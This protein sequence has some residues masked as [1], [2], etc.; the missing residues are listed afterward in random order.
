[1]SLSSSS[2]FSKGRGG[3]SAPQPPQAQQQQAAAE[4]PNTPRATATHTH[5]LKNKKSSLVWK[6]FTENE[7][8]KAKC[9]SEGCSSEYTV[10]NGSTTSMDMFIKNDT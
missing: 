6:Y 3:A 4:N 5:K 9:I 1:M 7:N 2:F 8:G 10:T